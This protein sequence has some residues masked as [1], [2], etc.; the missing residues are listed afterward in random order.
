MNKE[1]IYARLDRIKETLYGLECRIDNIKTERD[2]KELL[3]KK[4]KLLKELNKL[5]KRLYLN[6]EQ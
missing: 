6:N 5:E 2:R 3:K 4:T 1:R